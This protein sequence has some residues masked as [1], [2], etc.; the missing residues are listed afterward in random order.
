MV[1]ERIVI[2]FSLAAASPERM[3]D[4][5][6]WRSSS[7][8]E[9][10]KDTVVFFSGTGGGLCTLY[11]SSGVS[12][13][14]SRISSELSGKTRESFLNSTGEVTDDQPMGA[15]TFN[16]CLTGEILELND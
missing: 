12:V 15:I 6:F 10:G 11:F 13:S 3:A 2:L 1:L 8:S 5:M 7:G 4:R 9:L 16:G 14:F